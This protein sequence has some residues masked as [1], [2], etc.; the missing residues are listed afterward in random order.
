[1]P[2]FLNKVFTLSIQQEKR[3]FLNENPLPFYHFPTE[4]SHLKEG[5]GHVPMSRWELNDD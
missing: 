2:S 4:N 1:M 5:V 3:G